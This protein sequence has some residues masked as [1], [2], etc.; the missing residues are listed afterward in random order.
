[1]I[2]KEIKEKT[3]KWLSLESEVMIEVQKMI[4]DKKIDVNEWHSFLKKAIEKYGT[5]DMQIN[6]ERYLSFFKF[7]GEMAKVERKGVKK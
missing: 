1:M 7:L 2:S 3:I 6:F 5:I 4:K